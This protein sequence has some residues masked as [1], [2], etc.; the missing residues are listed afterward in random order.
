MKFHYRILKISV[1]NF[2]F[3]Q[4]SLFLIGSKSPELKSWSVVHYIFLQINECHFRKIAHFR[5][6][7]TGKLEFSHSLFQS[8]V[9]QIWAGILKNSEQCCF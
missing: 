4:K 7:K 6:E 8:R 5:F 1:N 2:T 9:I 3:Q